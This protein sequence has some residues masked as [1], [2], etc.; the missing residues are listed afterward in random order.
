M[1]TG[2]LITLG[3]LIS[4]AL[5]APALALPYDIIESAQ[6]GDEHAARKLLEQDP[7]LANTRDQREFT[8]LH[9]AGINGHWHI[10]KQLIEAGA[11]VNA[12]GGDG[13]SPLH[14]A[15]HHDRPDMIQL[16][17]DRGA[18]LSLSNQWGRTPLHVAARRGCYRVAG[19]LLDNRADPNAPTR[20][21][22]TPLHVA[23]KAGQP[24]LVELLL[25]RGAD[26][27]RKDE[28]GQ[29]PQDY[30]FTRPAAIG[31]DPEALDEFVGH[32]DLGSGGSFKIWAEDGGL[33]IREFAPDGIY[34]IGRDEF[35]CVQEPWRVTFRR[36]EAGGI[37]GVDVAFL[38]QTVHGVRRDH[39]RYVGSEACQSCH[40]R[41]DGGNQYMQWITSRH[42]AAYWRLATDWSKLLASFRPHFRDM[43]EPI[44]EDRCLLCHTTAAQDPDALLAAGFRREEGIGC[45]TCHG[46]GSLYLDPEVMADRE[47]F[48]SRGGIVPDEKTC[49]KCHRNPDGFDF[50]EW[51]PKIAHSRETDGGH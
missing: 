21:G 16:L 44:T 47:Q 4:L 9:W 28:A 43:T 5:P 11:P 1:R 6:R 46:P 38:R 39:P 45:E 2:A 10:F 35:Y 27:E 32:Y 13:G 31:L 30:A 25:A 49:Q 19:L 22:W 48:L 51:W 50:A 8:P 42:A 23:Y 24:E 33:R 3:L 34:P 14:W 7:N 37:E 40:L 20:E 36:N 17:L 26:P 29:R 12:V 15:C 41:G 18:D